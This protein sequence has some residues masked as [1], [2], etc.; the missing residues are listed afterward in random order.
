MKLS[1]AI[2][3]GC[4]GTIQGRN[5][6]FDNTFATYCAFGTAL[7]G[8]GI[9]D[10]EINDGYTQT[11]GYNK[12]KELWPEHNDFRFTFAHPLTG[13]QLI[14]RDTV[15]DLNDDKKWTREQIAEWLQTIGW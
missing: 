7:H 8:I 15:W 14:L 5:H 11:G 2:L 6:L 1:E 12:L 4:E 13:N 3:K 9:P 10:N